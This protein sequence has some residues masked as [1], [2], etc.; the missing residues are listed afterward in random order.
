MIL[1]GWAPPMPTAE[2]SSRWHGS[3][4]TSSIA[5]GAAHPAALHAHPGGGEAIRD[6]SED[7]RERTMEVLRLA[8][9]A[10]PCWV[11]AAIAVALVAVYFGFSYMRSPQLRQLWRQGHAL[12]RPVRALPRPRV[13]CPAAGAGCPLHAKAQAIG[14]A[15][16]LLE[17]LEAEVSEPASGRYPSRRRAP[18]GSKPAPWRC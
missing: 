16:Q 17:F 13:L 9:P 5:S 18:S 12:Y 1:V 14:A 11:F 8:F 4:V 3:P 10:P 6:A 15:E 7:F 2:T